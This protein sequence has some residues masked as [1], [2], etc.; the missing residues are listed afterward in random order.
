MGEV[1]EHLDKP[2]E[3]LKKLSSLLY[4]NGVIWITTP[5]NAPAIDHVYLFNNKQEII[6]L[7]NDSCLE[8]IES[9][10]CYAEEYLDEICEKRKVTQMVGLFCKKR[11]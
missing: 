10:G 6:D 1:L 3:M 11:N 9:F 7:A 2:G 5:T 8:V 4:P